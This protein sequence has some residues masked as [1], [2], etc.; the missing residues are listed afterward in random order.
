MVLAVRKMVQQACCMH[1]H[2]R[3]G[4]PQQELYAVQNAYKAHFDI[5]S[6]QDLYAAQNAYKAHVQIVSILLVKSKMRQQQKCSNVLSLF[7]GL[8]VVPEPEKIFRRRK[9]GFFCNQ[10]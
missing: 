1:L 4:M 9:S 6:L 5:V 10:Q 3:A 8:L 2:D 7:K